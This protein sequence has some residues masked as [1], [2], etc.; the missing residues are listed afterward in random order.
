[1][2]WCCPKEGPTIHYL[3]FVTLNVSFSFSIGAPLSS[4]AWL[5]VL[6]WRALRYGLERSGR[7][8]IFKMHDKKGFKQ[9]LERSDGVLGCSKPIFYFEQRKVDK[10]LAN[11]QAEQLFGKSAA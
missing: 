1:M 8:G 9:V 2:L 11:G 4:C 3:D 6:R 7:S 5:A 10:K